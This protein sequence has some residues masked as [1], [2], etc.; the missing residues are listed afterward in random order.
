M[1]DVPVHAEAGGPGRHYCLAA[2]VLVRNIPRPGPGRHTGPSPTRSRIMEHRATQA[3]TL[4][5]PSCQWP[6]TGPSGHGPRQLERRHGQPCRRR[7]SSSSNE[8]G[9]LPAAYATPPP[10]PPP[11]PPPS[12]SGRDGSGSQLASESR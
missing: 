1:R 2:G 4:L 12:E 7:H 10:P 8:A 9:A 5:L 11:P 3:G 6:G